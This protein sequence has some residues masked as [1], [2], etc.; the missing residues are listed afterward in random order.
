MEDV[1]PAPLP[2]RRIWIAVA[3]TLLA[4]PV[5]LLDTRRG[6]DGDDEPAGA[7]SGSVAAV[8][9][10]SLDR[11]ETGPPKGISVVTTS[12][13]SSTVPLTTTTTT[14]TT[15]PAGAQSRRPR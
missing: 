4:V 1:E 13:T 11:P 9:P 3:A 8:V 10:M 14:T 2:R 6:D 7:S 12:T 5:L 15:L